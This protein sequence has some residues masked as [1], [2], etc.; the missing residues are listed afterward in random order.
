MNIEQARF[1]MIEQQIR[2]NGVVDET[3]LKLLFN[4]KREKFV[5]EEMQ[6]LAFSDLEIPLPGEQKMLYPRVEAQLIQALNI[7]KT[8]KILEIGT[9]SGYV[10]A[11]LAKL[12]Q[13]VY[14]IEIDERNR[15]FAVHNLTKAGITNVSIINGNGINGFSEKAPYD[16]IFIGAGMLEISNNIKHEL[17][18]GGSLV[19]FS[20]EKPVMHA[21]LIERVA[22]NKYNQ[23][24]L[25]EVNIDYLISE[26][27][28]NFKF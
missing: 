6:N 16:K 3:I 7:K 20:G 10:T 14:S 18:I 17:K 26:Q 27:V 28:K 2:P 13:F 5:A 23:K 21:Q 8:D 1:N 15:Q 9:G 4:L 19:G 12:S 25:F 11:M 22:D 24:N